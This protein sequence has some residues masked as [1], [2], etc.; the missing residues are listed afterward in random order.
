MFLAVQVYWFITMEAPLSL[1]V[2]A[3]LAERN[4]L[5]MAFVVGACLVVCLQWVIFGFVLINCLFVCAWLWLSGFTEWSVQL[6]GL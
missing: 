6:R 5:W 3:Y 4:S 1:C 2:S